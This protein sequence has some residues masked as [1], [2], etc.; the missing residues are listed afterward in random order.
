MKVWQI[1]KKEVIPICEKC[2]DI[3]KDEKIFNHIG[4]K[5]Y[6]GIHEENEYRYEWTNQEFCFFCFIYNKIKNE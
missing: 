1:D 4:N 2:Y 5:D 6:K 3:F